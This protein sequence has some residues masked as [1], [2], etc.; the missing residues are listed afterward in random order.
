MIL[1]GKDQEGSRTDAIEMYNCF[2]NTW[3]SVPDLK[4]RKPRSGF[5]SVFLRHEQKILVIGGNDGRV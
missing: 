1:G 3:K 4:L 2:D 5:A